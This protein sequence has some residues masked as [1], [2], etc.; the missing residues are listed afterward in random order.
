MV[1]IRPAHADGFCRSP[2][3]EVRLVLVYGPDAGL[4]QERAERLVESEIGPDGDPFR[5]SLL[6]GTEVA[7]D[8]ARLGDEVA[9]LSLTGGRR[10]VRVREAGDAL[11]GPIGDLLDGGLGDALVV[12][13][14]GDLGPRSALRRVA[15]AAR[16]G[17]AVPCYRDT[18]EALDDFIAAALARL[19]IGVSAEARDYLA[20]RLGND[21]AISRREL[22]KLALYMR[23]GGT[24]GLADVVASIGDSAAVTLDDAVMAAAD[25]DT[26]AL[27]AV[28]LRLRNSGEEP[29]RVLR[30]AAR[31][32]Q[33]LL[34][35]V[36]R[37][38]CG[39]SVA[40][41]VAAL[42]PPVFFKLRPRVQ[43]QVGR[44]CR[45]GLVR[46]LERLLEGE[47]RCKSTGAPAPLLAQRIM[48]ETAAAA[49]RQRKREFESA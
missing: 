20:H 36:G 9:A 12:V 39:M 22:E 19:G 23:G 11:A 29:I 25:G 4:V 3:P 44:W 45:T 47:V 15:E 34:T 42:R 13:E 41:A 48:M 37:V 16:D 8:P 26:E 6:S 28:M 30:A 40:D 43:A 10:V 14:A 31:H 49:R 35:A 2:P 1:K 5:L 24:A 21:R 7:G 27:D 33:R 17:A 46:T 32:F 18:G 38:E